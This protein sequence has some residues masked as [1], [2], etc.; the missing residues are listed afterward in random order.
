M[1]CSEKELDVIWPASVRLSP[2][3]DPLAML[4]RNADLVCE[5]S[6]CFAS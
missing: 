1:T 5:R 6:P 3:L 2:I 4:R